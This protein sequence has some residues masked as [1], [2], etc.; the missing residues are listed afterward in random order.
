M[1]MEGALSRM[2]LNEQRDL[3]D[4]FKTSCQHKGMVKKRVPTKKGDQLIPGCKVEFRVPINGV[5]AK[6]G[7]SKGFLMFGILVSV[8]DYDRCDILCDNGAYEVD[9]PSSDVR[10]L[11]ANESFPSGSKTN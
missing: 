3:L 9:V 4:Q 2:I 5:H 1:L 7:A 6:A 10:V 8:S 11:D